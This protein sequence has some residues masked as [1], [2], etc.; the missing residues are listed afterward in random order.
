MNWPAAKRMLRHGAR[1]TRPNWI[2]NHFWVLSKDGFERILCHDGTNARVHL[3][4]IEG[5][6]WEIFEEKKKSLSD[7]RITIA[8][9]MHNLYFGYLEDDAKIAVKELNKEIDQGIKDVCTGDCSMEQYEKAYEDASE[10]IK[11]C[12]EEIFGEKLC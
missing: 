7:E 6:N 1:I 10:N 2:E 5:E 3:E 12:I 4:Q 9:D 8:K 11:E